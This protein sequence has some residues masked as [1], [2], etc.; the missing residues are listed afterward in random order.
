MAEQKTDQIEQYVD[1]NEKNFV[2]TGSE[3]VESVD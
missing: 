1:K 2:E 3:A